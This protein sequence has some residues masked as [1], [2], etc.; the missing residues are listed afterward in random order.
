MQQQDDTQQA[1]ELRLAFLRHL[2]KRLEMLRKRGQRL[3]DQG[4]DINALTLLFRE[5]QPLAGACGRYGLLDIGEHLFSLEGF[6]AP[7]VE[8][9]SIPNANQTE[10]F[11]GLLGKLEPLIAQHERQYGEPADS[12]AAAALTVA[13]EQTGG[14]P[15]QVTPPPEYW[16][17]F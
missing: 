12:Q 14:F 9:I 2:P 17:R 7:F 6:L 11:A 13:T 3:C 15:L 10:S 5:V 1:A 4:W 8:Q 16:K